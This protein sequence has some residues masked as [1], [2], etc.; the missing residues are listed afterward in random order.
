MQRRIIEKITGITFSEFVGQKMLKPCGMASAIVDPT[1]EDTLIAKSYNDNHQQDGLTYPI[2]G[3]TCVTLDD[4]YKW[5]QS[6]AN[7][8]L[9]SPASMLE[10]ITPIA[11]GKQCGLGGGSM[12]DGRVI[13]HVHDGI[14]Q[15]YQALLASYMPDERTVILLTN[16][17]QDN[18]YEINTA[19]QNILN[20]KPYQQPAKSLLKVYQKQIDTTNGEHL[21]GLYNKLRAQYPQV[22]GF[23]NESTL[24]ELGYYLMGN[25]RIKDAILIFKLNTALFPASGNVFDSLGEAYY[26]S[27]DRKNAL[28]NYQ[29][30]VK[31][32]P[33][34]SSGKEII[35]QLQKR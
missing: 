26:K 34:N 19:I 6:I 1:D 35:S 25:S 33:T 5:S 13:S 7:F 16:N 24:N 15:H 4:F 18:V 2:S 31:L 20:D 29:I 32:D 11:P 22:Y 30:S 21:I 28:L 14:A 12:A 27:G 9:I 10:I 17:K 23:N 3:W 8:K